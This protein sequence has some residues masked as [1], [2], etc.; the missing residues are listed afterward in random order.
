MIY[1]TTDS[2]RSMKAIKTS[3]GN[4]AHRTIFSDDVKIPIRKGEF[5]IPLFTADNGKAIY[6]C[7][8]KKLDGTKKRLRYQQKQKLI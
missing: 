8:T 5:M 2:F 7:K 3:I 1:K 4:L 6:R